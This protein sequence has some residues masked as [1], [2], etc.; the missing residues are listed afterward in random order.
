MSRFALQCVNALLASVTIVVAGASILG[1]AGSPVYGGEVGEVPAALDSNLRFM[2]G[3]GLGLGG[4]LVWIT[5][6][7]ERHGLL[8]RGAWLC[9]FLGGIG[10]VVSWHVAGAPPLAMMVFTVIELP[11]VPVLIYWQWRVAQGG[12]GSNGA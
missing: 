7:I 6:A 9:A 8:F 5:P 1:G 2:G 12:K 3:M 10:R 4:I 11:L